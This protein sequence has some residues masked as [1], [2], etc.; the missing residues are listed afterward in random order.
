MNDEK[1]A[2]YIL[3]DNIDNID[4]EN[5]SLIDY[6]NTIEFD[7]DDMVDNITYFLKNKD[8]E[9]IFGIPHVYETTGNEKYECKYSC[10]KIT[11]SNRFTDLGNE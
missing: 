7:D 11:K 6:L 9:F 5:N 8:A 10:M 1:V 2:K 4:C 3:F